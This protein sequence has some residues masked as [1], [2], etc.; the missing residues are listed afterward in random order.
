MG[1][2]YSKRMSLLPWVRVNLGLHGVSYTVGPRGLSFTFGRRGVYAN[3]SLPGTG[4]SYRQRLG[5][6][7][8][9]SSAGAAVLLGLLI[10][11]G[12]LLLLA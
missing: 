11:I 8:P 2:R 4:L 9:R 1:W 7:S 12:L 5:Q 3:A 10:G 6:A